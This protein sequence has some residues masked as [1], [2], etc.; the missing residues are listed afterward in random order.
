MQ[1]SAEQQLVHLNNG[2][3]MPSIRNDQLRLAGME[4][5]KIEQHIIKVRPKE[6]QSGFCYLSQVKGTTF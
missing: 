1:F 3:T 2:V 4:Q 5:L 6:G